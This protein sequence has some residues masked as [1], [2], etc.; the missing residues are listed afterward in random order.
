[1]QQEH[2]PKEV[3]I[4]MGK[5]FVKTAIMV[6]IVIAM[7]DWYAHGMIG[8]L[9]KSMKSIPK[10]AT[11]STP[12]GDWSILGLGATGTDGATGVYKPYTFF[13]QEFYNKPR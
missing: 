7:L 2:N 8:R 4:E 9:Y 11:D 10:S 3:A 5:E 1:M 6:L 12:S 13:G